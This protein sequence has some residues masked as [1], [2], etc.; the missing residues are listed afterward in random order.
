MNKRTVKTTMIVLMLLV[1]ALYFVSGTYARYAS[2]FEG[3]ATANVAQWSIDSEAINS[4]KFTV[5]DNEFVMKDKIAPATTATAETQ[6][7][8]SGTEVA[9]DVAIEAAD[10]F[11]SKLSDLGLDAT[12]LTLKI[13]KSEESTVTVEEGGL[14]TKENPFVC[15]L[16]DD[17]ATALSG[18][19]NLKITLEWKDEGTKWNA[20]D[21]KNVKDTNVGT[22]GGTLELPVKVIVQQHIAEA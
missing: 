4:L 17:G 14:G 1:V 9:V 10:D 22:T 19:L 13:E 18:T 12:Q 6:I 8:L 15:K 2:E 20:K 16:Q 11:A 5:D 3:T 7:D 21:E